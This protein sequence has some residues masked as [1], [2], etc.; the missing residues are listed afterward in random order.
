MYKQFSRLCAFTSFPWLSPCQILALE[1]APGATCRPSPFSF[2]IPL[3]F[4][5]FLLS[6]RSPPVVACAPRPANVVASARAP[7]S[8]SHRTARFRLHTFLVAFPFTPLPVYT[9]YTRISHLYIAYFLFTPF[10]THHTRLSFLV[11]AI[12]VHVCIHSFRP[13]LQLFSSSCSYT[14]S[15]AALDE[16]IHEVRHDL[17][18]ASPQLMD[19]RARES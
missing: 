5:S 19:L 14:Y 13:F 11:F 1:G 7:D 17:T 3:L 8:I 4:L 2:L 10:T 15:L 6:S 12:S 9:C 16:Y 18:S